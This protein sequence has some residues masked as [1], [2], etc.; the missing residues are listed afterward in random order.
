MIIC[1]FI[2]L[3]GKSK[4][5][6]RAIYHALNAVLVKY[7]TMSAG[8]SDKTQANRR[9][10]IAPKRTSMATR[11]MSTVTSES[12]ENTAVSVP[13]ST[14]LSSIIQRLCPACR[15]ARTETAK[16]LS[17]AQ[18]LRCVKGTLT[19]FL[20]YLLTYSLTY[21]LTHLLTHSL[22]HSQMRICSPA[23]CCVSR[24]ASAALWVHL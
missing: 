2:I 19:Y 15:V 20:T 24:I 1:I 21:L 14:L 13:Q 9:I 17:F 7:S 4:K 8:A 5:E 6:M 18:I 3:F 22:T 11:R 10:S 23:E 12:T 16:Y